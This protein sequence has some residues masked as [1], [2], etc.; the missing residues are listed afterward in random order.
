MKKNRSSKPTPAAPIDEAKVARPLGKSPKR[1]RAPFCLECGSEFVSVEYTDDDRG[2]KVDE[3]Y[4]LQAASSELADY[5]AEMGT[6]DGPT[7]VRVHLAQVTA[8][9]HAMWKARTQ[10]HLIA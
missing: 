3:L 7:D 8:Y 4:A 6:Q 10:R 9:V 5:L 1:H 2:E